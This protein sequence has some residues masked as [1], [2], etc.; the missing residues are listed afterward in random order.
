M[1]TSANEKVYIVV[2][3][4]RSGLYF[5]W[6]ECDEQAKGYKGNIFKS[7]ET[8][9]EAVAKWVRIKHRYGV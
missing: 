5:S 8:Y 9:G 7:L 4:R 6:P 3:G 1:A 2:E